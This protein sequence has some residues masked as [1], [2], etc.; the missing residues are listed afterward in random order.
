MVKT[1]RLATCLLLS[2]VFAVAWAKASAQTNT[3]S[4]SND[5]YL[6]EFKGNTVPKDFK[7]A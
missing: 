7:R 2:I 3:V 1:V 4:G 5:Q 6:V